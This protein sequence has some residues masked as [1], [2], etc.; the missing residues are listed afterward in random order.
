MVITKIGTKSLPELTGQGQDS[1]LNRDNK[2]ISGKRRQIQLPRLRSLPTF[3]VVGIAIYYVLDWPLV[4]WSNFQGQ[5]KFADLTSV[6]NSAICFDNQN[7]GI[8]TQATEFAL[9]ENC[10][11]VY[12]KF[13]LLFL[14]KVGIPVSY[15]NLIGTVLILAVSLIV[16][17]GFLSNRFR[18]V[19]PLIQVFILLSALSPA[20]SLLME[21]GNLD[22]FCLIL[23][24]LSAI[25][26]WKKR[27]FLGL[28]FLLMSALV[29]FYT[30]PLAIILTIYIFKNKRSYAAVICTT[31]VSIEVFIELLSL[32]DFLP[33]S[34]FASFGIT[35][36]GMNLE[37]IGLPLNTLTTFIL[38]FLS[39]LCM[40][41]FLKKLTP[42]LVAP[43][44]KGRFDEQVSLAYV[45]FSTVFLSCYFLG[46]SYDYRL[47]FLLLA[48]SLY[49]MITPIK[50]D[51]Q[52]F[53][54]ICLILSTWLSF[55]SSYLQILGDFSILVWVVILTISLRIHLKFQ[56]ANLRDDGN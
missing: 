17:T 18:L 23:I 15:A 3:F 10:S 24:S 49:L 51:L 27:N 7:G 19:R 40:Y 52:I 36:F 32:K 5:M 38:G 50:S 6:L 28:L 4:K 14:S 48:A 43:T 2:P 33:K 20:I 35:I 42:S 22:S 34:D 9:P 12:G 11:Y 25:S 30:I 29:K 16:L 26:T 21:R 55:N 53:L 1:H 47:V 39:I 46:S 54:G 37:R 56:Y 31:F 8:T 13:L 44:F 41:I 45:F